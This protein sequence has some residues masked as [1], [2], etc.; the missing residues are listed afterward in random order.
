MGIILGTL[1]LLLGFVIGS[2]INALSFRY[3]SGK[4]I[5]TRSVCFSC[6]K[7]IYK[8]DLVPVLSFLLLKGR[9]RFCHSK[10]SFQYPFVEVLSGLVFLATFLKFRIFLY[11]GVFSTPLFLW[12]VFLHLAFWSAFL[13]ISIYD[14][15]HKIVPNEAVYLMMLLGALPLL[16]HFYMPIVYTASILFVCFFSLWFFSSGRLIGFGD[17]KIILAL[18]LFFN[19]AI[20]VS[21]VF[22]SFWIGALYSVFALLSQ[23]VGL[24]L[25]GK[26]LT[27]KSEVPFVPFMFLGFLLAFWFGFDFLSINALMGL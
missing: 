12:V 25:G 18:G 14:L 27:I 19:P 3:D 26:K 16:F 20:A 9:C 4:S 10:I 8:R 1:F 22:L 2:F 6:G 17:V 7:E 23:K 11:S 21:G 13:F 24:N 5:L 15:K